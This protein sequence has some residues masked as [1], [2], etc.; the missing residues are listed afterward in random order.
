VCATNEPALTFGLRVCVVRRQ[1]DNLPDFT[2]T[3][4]SGQFV[5]LDQGNGQIFDYV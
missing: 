2:F 1:T 5:A 4:F 3:Y